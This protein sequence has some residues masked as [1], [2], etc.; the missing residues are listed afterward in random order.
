VRRPIAVIDC[1]TDPFKRYRVPR[2]FVWGFFDGAEYVQF[3]ARPDPKLTPLALMGRVIAFL[4]EFDGIVYAHNGGRFDWHFLLPGASA[5]DDI[6]II[7]GRIARMNIGAAE[8]R[9]SYNIIPVPLAAYKKDEID[10]GIMEESERFKP[11][12]WET[13][14]AYLRNDC[15]YLHELVSQ[16]VKQ[17]GVQLT[18]AGAAMKQWKKISK[19]PLPESTRSFYDALSPYYYGGRV[20]CFEKGIIEDEFSVYDIN[21]AYPR[22]MLERHPYSTEYMQVDGYVNSADFV[23]VR[24][25]PLGAFPF[26]GI[27]GND[28]ANGLWFPADSEIREYTVTHWEY[29]AALETHTL[30]LHEVIESIVFLEHVDFREYVEHFYELRLKAKAEKDDASSLFAKLLMNSLYGK[31]AS[32]PENYRNYMIVPM[33]KMPGLGAGAM[34]DW[35]F[36]G[37]LGP[38]ALA[39]APLAPEQERYYNVATSASITGWVRAYLWRAIC[40]SKGVIYC[41]TDSMAVRTFGA[42]LPQGDLLGQWKHEGAFDRAGIAGKKLYIFRGI[43]D[44]KGARE[45]KRAS[46]GARLTN[47]QLWTVARG[48]EVEYVPEVPTFSPQKAPAFTP[49]RLRFTAT[50]ARIASRL[51]FAA[52]MLRRARAAHVGQLALD[53]DPPQ[54]SLAL[55]AVAE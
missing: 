34:A 4:E 19:R 39:S 12:N 52:S 51:T 47:T 20:Q 44:A 32:N 54:Q 22:A 16:F 3:P 7:N 21:S 40:A 30:G 45:Y 38:W 42:K 25:T 26:R 31:F 23:R 37:E 55:F 49:R 6:M 9:D 14:T 17:Y 11:R 43:P 53:F 5:Y 27:H 1:E 48:G 18:Q 33:D 41:D 13:I 10:Y 50:S 2:P 29:L 36:A 15:V 28:V 46:K 24:G 8:C 35:H